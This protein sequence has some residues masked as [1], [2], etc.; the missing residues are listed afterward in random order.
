MSLFP[1]PFSPPSIANLSALKDYLFVL[2]LFLRKQN[3]DLDVYTENIY[4]QQEEII[5]IKK[6]TLESFLLKNKRKKY[7]FLYFI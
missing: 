1:H 4:T 6:K 2:I 7:Y 3:Q 5:R